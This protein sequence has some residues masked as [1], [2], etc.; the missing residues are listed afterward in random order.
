LK[1]L[2][3]AASQ[4]RIIE[5]NVTFYRQTA[6]KHDSYETYI[7]DPALQQSLEDDLDKIGLHFAGLDRSPSC[8]ECGGG[9]GNLTLKMCKRG[10]G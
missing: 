1:A 2:L 5:A 8:L 3:I 10:W 6:E 9:T 4:K 7:F